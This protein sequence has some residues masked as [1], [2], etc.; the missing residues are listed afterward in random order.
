MSSSS[1]GGP[2]GVREIR[3]L[4][5]TVTENH[6]RYL[7][8]WGLVRASGGTREYSFADLTTI[9][10]V[11]GELERGTPLK[12][13][14]RGLVAERHG[15]LVL[16]FHAAPDTPRAKVVTLQAR[17][18]K[19]PA[20]SPGAPL[21]ASA[22]SVRDL[23]FPF[24]RSAGGARRTVLHRSVAPGRRKSEA[25]GGGGGRVSPGARH[26]SRPRPRDRQPRQHPLRARR[27]DR[28]A[29]PLRAGAGPRAAT[30]SRPTSTWATSTTT[31]AASK[32]R[33]SATGTR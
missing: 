21:P 9:K 2:F 18:P 16:D 13:L 29:G 8:K 20:V 27:D 26:R 23:G 32:P 12:V 24:S 31:W 19:A 30:V 25:H 33:W 10:H 3:S 4:Y 14:L 7:E 11:A 15:Q 22:D 5:P 6:L 28:G 17:R 1:T